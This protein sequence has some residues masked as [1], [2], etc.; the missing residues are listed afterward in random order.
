MDSEKKHIPIWKLSMASS[1]QAAL[2]MDPN[3][4]K[5]K[6]I[7]KNSE[8]ENIESLF[9]VMNLMI[10]VNSELKTLFLEVRERN[11][12]YYRLRRQRC[13]LSHIVA[14]VK[15]KLVD[16]IEV[17]DVFVEGFFSG[18]MTLLMFNAFHAVPE[19][20]GLKARSGRLLVFSSLLSLRSL[21]GTFKNSLHSGEKV[22]SVSETF[23]VA[24]V[25]V[26]LVPS[27]MDKLAQ[28]SSLSVGDEMTL[29]LESVERRSSGPVSPV[30]E[31]R[32]VPHRQPLCRVGFQL[33]S[34]LHIGFPSAALLFC[35][36]GVAA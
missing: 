32:M 4:A 29:T 30:C 19:Q 35:V 23:P 20:M 26:A 13:R 33:V 28:A 15:A 6:E 17:S 21:A 2:H 31:G 8:F 12:P 10:A 22:S 9:N 24:V 7:F 3:Y 1:M 5:N 34:W 25:N 18:L 16:T 14:L 36:Q 11:W 27:G